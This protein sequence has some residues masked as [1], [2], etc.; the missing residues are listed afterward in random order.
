MK[1][2]RYI[3][4]GLVAAGIITLLIVISIQYQSA[5]RTIEEQENKID[6]LQE[7]N[8]MLVDDVFIMSQKLEK[9]H[10]EHAE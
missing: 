6:A 5:T 1:K 8:A 2:T 7:E 4:S 3:T 10:K 9:E